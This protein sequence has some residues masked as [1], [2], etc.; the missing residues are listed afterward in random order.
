MVG[1]HNATHNFF[2]VDTLCSGGSNCTGAVTACSAGTYSTLSGESAEIENLPLGLK[3]A[4]S[5]VKSVLPTYH[6]SIHYNSGF[7]KEPPAAQLW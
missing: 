7:L 2:S 6:F 4:M 3:Y 5:K 1:Q